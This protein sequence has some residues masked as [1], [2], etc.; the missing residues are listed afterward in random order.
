M[1]KRYHYRGHELSQE[2]WF[3]NPLDL[4][5]NPILFE[6]PLS[7]GEKIA[8]GVAVLAAVGV[9][10]YFLLRPKPA[11]A[12][13]P[14]GSGGN[15]AP[16]PGPTGTTG[17]APPPGP[18]GTTG[19]APPPGPTGTTGAAPPPPPAQ[20]TWKVATS[21]QQ[22]QHYRASIPVLL[23]NGFVTTLPQV[24]YQNG[25]THYGPQDPIPADWPAG[26]DPGMTYDR[27]DFVSQVTMPLPPLPQGVIFWEQS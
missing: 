14:S 20:A 22:G 7:S 16:P 1:K 21:L 8:I 10:A 6:N 15:T 11:A 24:F 18:T 17:A 2:G 23:T 19:A 9:G 4:M 5:E 13:T 3:S 26:E 25:L 27:F 12:G